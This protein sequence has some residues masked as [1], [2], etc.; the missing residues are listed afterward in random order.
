[1]APMANGAP[2]LAVDRCCLQ[3]NAPFAPLVAH[4]WS[5]PGGLPT[6][7][8]IDS[9]PTDHP[10]SPTMSTTTRRFRF[11]SQETQVRRTAAG[12]ALVMAMSVLAAL[13]QVADGQYDDALMAHADEVPTQVV[14]VS[15]K[16]LPA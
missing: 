16:R 5:R 8:S 1:V 6:V 11:S 7:R 13:G 12:V 2:G 14:V 9:R 3:F 10:R 4:R 15:A